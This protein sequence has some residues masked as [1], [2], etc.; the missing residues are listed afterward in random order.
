MLGVLRDPGSA[1]RL[2]LGDWDSLLRFAR[3]AGALPRL[4]ANL[5]ENGRLEQV[6]HPVRWHLEAQQ[7]FTE[8]NHGRIRAELRCLAAI[9]EGLE[10]PL[11]LLKGAAYLA[12]DSPV[13]AGRTCSDIDLLTTREALAD[14]ETRLLDVGYAPKDIPPRDARYFRRWLHEIPPMHHRYRGVEIDVHHNVLPRTDKLQFDPHR[15]LEQTTPAATDPRFHVLGPSDQVL[16]AAAHLFRNGD[17]TRGLRDL[18]DLDLLL[19]RSTEGAGGWSDLLDRAEALRMQGPCWLAVRYCTE[20]LH[21]P[22]PSEAASRLSRFQP[23]RLAA[24]AFDRYVPAAL[25]PGR[26][27]GDDERRERAVWL[28]A[29]YP[30]PRP[31]AM[32]SPLFWLKRLPAHGD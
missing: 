18:L 19:R 27:D 23:S 1:G 32:L 15:L 11:V 21:T 17:F 31:R 24:R 8:F 10:A 16:H 3:L 9:L 5:L 6:P 30:L 28:L 29:H 25:F 14:V 12:D 13:A 26:I 22:V 7:Q 2:N 4:A 20:F